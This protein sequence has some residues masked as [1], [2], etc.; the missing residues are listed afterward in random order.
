MKYFRKLAHSQILGNKVQ[1]LK[2]V[3]GE[4]PVVAVHH[5]N[6]GQNPGPLINTMSR[7]V[8]ADVYEL[9]LVRSPVDNERHGALSLETLGV[10]RNVS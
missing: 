2:S 5:D 1:V 10:V 4:L 9:G 3:A 7:F 8:P 6:R